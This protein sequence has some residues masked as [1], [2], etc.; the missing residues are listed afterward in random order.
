MIRL[1]LLLCATIGIGIWLAK[2]MTF[3]VR[4][5][6]AEVAPPVE[7]LI[8]EVE[9][10]AIDKALADAVQAELAAAAAR[11]EAEASEAAAPES[12]AETPEET[13]LDAP[14]TPANVDPTRW[15]VAADKINVRS[16]PGTEFDVVAQ[17]F[18][19]EGVTTLSDPA[20]EWVQIRLDDGTEAY[21]ASRFLSQDGG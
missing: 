2:S 4:E 15:F 5:E 9:R 20:A 12:P 1:V 3:T 13:A 18:R 14:A 10:N 16:G 8:P 11:R 17:A 21:V 7:E 19:G 6:Q